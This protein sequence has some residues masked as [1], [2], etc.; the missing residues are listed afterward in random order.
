MI[1][2]EEALS[3]IL[4]S[5]QI[6]D[7]EEQPLLDCLGQVLAEE[8]RAY[9]KT[10]MI[11]GRIQNGTIYDNDWKVKENMENSGV[12]YRDW[13]VGNRIRNGRIHGRV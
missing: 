7:S 12:F 6:L 4:N 10:W 9:D 2:V 8:L 13:K 1:S 3:K 11:K 5:I